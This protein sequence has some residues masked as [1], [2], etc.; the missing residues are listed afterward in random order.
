VLGAALVI[1]AQ[2][3]ITAVAFAVFIVQTIMLSGF[4]YF[5]SKNAISQHFNAAPKGRVS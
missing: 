5:A 4:T 3:S 1:S 2:F